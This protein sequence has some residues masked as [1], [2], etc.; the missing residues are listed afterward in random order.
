MSPA[1]TSSRSSRL[2]STGRAP[3]AR[4]RVGI[5]SWSQPATCDGVCLVSDYA[6]I[7]AVELER[8]YAAGEID[9]VAVWRSVRERMDAWE[10]LVHATS[11]RD[12]ATA[13]T[14]ARAAAGRWATMR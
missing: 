12:E 11:H 8:G 5:G 1:R 6:E 7:T 10:P 9:P 14:D 2:E 13:E 4:G 3:A